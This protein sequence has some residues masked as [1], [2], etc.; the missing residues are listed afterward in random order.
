MHF[1]HAEASG[2][3]AGG[4]RHM[5]KQIIPAILTKNI[6]DYQNKITLVEKLVKRV[7]IDI[8]DGKFVPNKTISLTTI[9]QVQTKLHK[10]AHLMV[11]MPWKYVNS[12]ANARINTFIF[13]IEACPTTEQVCQTLK[14]ISQHKM[15]ASIAISPE[16]PVDKILPYLSKLE[17]V[18]IMTV[19]PGFGGQNLIPSALQKVQALKEYD[20]KLTIEVD[21]GINKET[22]AL[23][24]QAG[25]NYFVMGSAIYAHKN[26]KE[27]IKNY[28]ILL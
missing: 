25:A 9:R 10:E 24:V 4:L 2:F 11:K 15:Q 28:K 22:L 1:R 8:M 20:P 23:A 19:N 5:K 16:T 14:L 7:H 13:H 26:I 21:G 17:H 27:T 12:A 18:L 3:R 6:N